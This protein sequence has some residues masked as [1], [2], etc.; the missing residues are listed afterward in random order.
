MAQPKL[1]DAARLFVVQSLAC[2]DPPSAVAE[3]VRKEFGVTVSRQTVEGYDPTKRAGAKLMNKWKCLFEAARKEFLEK[4]TDI[5][6]AHRSV[7]LRV[8]QRMIDAAEA[9]KN[10]GLVAQL[11]EQAAKE[12][13]DAYTNTR[14]L[15]GP[16]G[17]PLQVVPIV[18]SMTPQQ[19]AQA[20]AA[21]IQGGP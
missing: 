14:K 1:T 19:A 6:I 4:A 8:L 7:R 21:T 16:N 5:P 2:F 10:Y 15:T 12:C 9:S 20:Y 3:A 17:G 11:L 13:G 18:P